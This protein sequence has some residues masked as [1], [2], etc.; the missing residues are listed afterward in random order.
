MW[1]YQENSG[2]A[3]CFAEVYALVTGTKLHEN[4]R[5]TMVDE[6]VFPGTIVSEKNNK[7]PLEAKDIENNKKPEEENKKLNIEIN[8]EIDSIID[9]YLD[10]K[11]D[12]FQRAPNE[13][14][15][16]FFKNLNNPEYAVFGIDSLKAFL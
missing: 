12:L 13:F 14:K 5:K 8:I 11:S 10:L 9:E 3:R 15:K 6:G 7:L 4:E 2:A 1:H 16:K